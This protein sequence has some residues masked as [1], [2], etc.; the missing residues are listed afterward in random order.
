MSERR[1]GKCENDEYLGVVILFLQKLIEKIRKAPVR[2]G[3]FEQ[4]RV[5]S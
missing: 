5:K 1:E 2:T 3:V 4:V